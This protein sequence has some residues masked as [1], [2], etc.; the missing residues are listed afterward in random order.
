MDA[1]RAFFRGRRGA[2]LV[3]EAV[4]KATAAGINR[5]IG[6]TANQLSLNLDKTLA[7][8][9]LTDGKAAVLCACDILPGL[10]NRSTNGPMVVKRSG[11]WRRSCRSLSQ[12]SWSRKRASS[13]RSRGNRRCAACPGI[14][15]RRNL[16]A[17]LQDMLRPRARALSS[18]SR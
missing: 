18:R 7:D 6:K 15:P 13:W 10:M 12:I 11:D 2:S 3:I 1:L 14:R 4:A 17:M 16:G 5:N 9:L 8:K